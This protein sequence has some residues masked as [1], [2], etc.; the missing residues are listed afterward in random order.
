VFSHIQEGGLFDRHILIVSFLFCLLLGILSGE[1]TGEIRESRIGLA[2]FIPAGI[3]IAALGAF[4]VGATH[5]YMEW[6][7]IRW[8]MGRALLERGV[9]PLTIA[10]G[11]EFNAWNNYDTFVARGNIARVYHWWYDRPDY[12]ISMAPLDGYQI[13]QAGQYFSWIHRCPVSLYVLKK[14]GVRN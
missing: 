9:D 5:D 3:A 7:R 11:F 10:G 1:G 14:N 4:C 6:N 2:R 8:D 12:I 13:R